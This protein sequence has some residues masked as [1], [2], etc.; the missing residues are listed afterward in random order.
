MIFKSYTEGH[1][2]P[3]SKR[4]QRTMIVSSHKNRIRRSVCLLP[5]WA[6]VCLWGRK[7]C[8]ANVKIGFMKFAL[9]PETVY[10]R[11]IKFLQVI[12]ENLDCNLTGIFFNL[13]FNKYV[14]IF[15]FNDVK[16]CYIKNHIHLFK[17]R[18]RTSQSNLS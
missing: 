16:F 9:F 11:E 4:I 18:I 2:Y 15:C 7:A 3:W 6:L 14:D 17:P 12:Y 5:T 8:V 10:R 1:E 13:G